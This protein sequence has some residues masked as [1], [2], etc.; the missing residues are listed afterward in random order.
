MEVVVAMQTVLK[1]L[2]IALLGAPIVNR[3]V[4]LRKTGDESLP[5]HSLTKTSLQRNGLKA[6]MKQELQ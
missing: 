1:Q 5:A 6:K 2:M 4:L 3:L